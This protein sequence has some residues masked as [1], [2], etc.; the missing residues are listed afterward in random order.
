MIKTD[1]NNKGFTLLSILIATV[2]GIF[3]VGVAGKIYVDTSN[4]FR[5]RSS[6]SA[7]AENARFALQDLRRTLIMAGR[8]IRAGE[9]ELAATR[10]FAPMGSTG[11]VDGGADG[12][13]I[14][15][16]RYRS[17]PSCAGNLDIPLTSAPATIRFLVADDELQCQKDNDPPRPVV[18][19]IKLM[20]VL[21]GVDDS[22]DGSAD[23]YL[24][25]SVVDN[26]PPPAGRAH[27]WVNVVALR[28][29]LVST[30]EE[31]DLPST[32]RG[33][34]GQ[35]DVLGM[36]YDPPDDKQFY[37]VATTTVSMRNLNNIMQRQ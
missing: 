7:V 26:L 19:G 18:S 14:V 17:G 9:D 5:A 31:P 16:V 12:S 1:A 25:A 20:K 24:T 10:P 33:T 11:T 15:A 36:S 28:I 2:I 27:P 37:K 6:L 4:T 8:N 34:T 22:G 13:D 35:L 29:G 21:Y 32:M 23:R 3:V 30:S